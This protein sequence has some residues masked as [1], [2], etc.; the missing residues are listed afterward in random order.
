MFS[1]KI[2]RCLFVAAI[3]LSAPVL[4]ARDS[5]GLARSAYGGTIRPGIA[6]RLSLRDST[7]SAP[8]WPTLWASLAT[9]KINAL[10]GTSGTFGL[11]FSDYQVE[12]PLWSR[13]SFESPP[14]S[15]FGYLFG[16]AIW[17]G[18]IVGN[19]T[20]VSVGNDGWFDARDF[21][22]DNYSPSGPGSIRP[23]DSVG[24][25]SL[26]SQ[27]TDTIQAGIP[28]RP[29]SMGNPHVPLHIALANHAHVWT[30]PPYN[31]CLVYDLVITN[32]GT[33]AIR[34]GYVGMFV[35][36]DVEGPGNQAN[37]AR[38]DIVGSI[39]DR[40]LG[41]IID[42]DGDP[43]NGAFDPFN[44]PRSLLG[45]KYLASSFQPTDTSFNWWFG[46]F[47]P[48]AWVDFGPQHRAQLRQLGLGGTGQ[49]VTDAER[50]FLMSGK[51]WDYDQVQTASISADDSVWAT[52][53]PASL[54]WCQGEDVRF[55]LSIGPFDLPPDSSVRVL[56]AY[57]IGD[58]VHSD[59]HIMDYLPLAPDLYTQSLDFKHTLDA[60]SA[61]DSLAKLVLA[62]DNP[63]TGLK[64]SYGS[65]DTVHLSWDPWCFDNLEGYNV[66]LTPVPDSA[67]VH[68][69]VLPIWYQPQTPLLRQRTGRVSEIDLTGMSGGSAYSVALTSTTGGISGKLSTSLI[70]K[71]GFRSGVPVV[72]DTMIFTQNSAPVSFHW[73][74]STGAA[75]QHYNIYRFRD[76]AEY[77]HRY[78]PFYSADIQNLSPVDSVVRNGQVY[79]YFALPVLATVPGDQRSFSDSTAPDG[80]LLCV[81]AVDSGGFESDFSAPATVVRTNRSKDVL[82]LTD[83]NPSL[84]FVY[85]SIIKAFYSQ[86]LDGYTWDFFSLADTLQKQDCPGFSPTCFDWHHLMPYRLVIIDDGL[87]DDV[88]TYPIEQATG[89]F[90]RFLESGGRLAY[91]GSFTNMRQVPLDAAA[92]PGFV[93]IGNPF[94]SHYFGIDSVFYYGMFYYQQSSA[95]QLDSLYG[96]RSADSG[97]AG[98]PSLTIDSAGTPFSLRLKTYWQAASPPMVSTFKPNARG[99]VTHIY[100]SLDPS[101]SVNEQQPVGVS[102]ATD[103]SQTYAFGF[104]LWYMNPL[105]ARRLVD[106]IVGRSSTGRPN[107]EVTETPLTFAL[108]QNYPNPF[109]PT[110]R[111]GFELPRAGQVTMV[112]FNILGQ[113]VRELAN[114]AYAAG[115]H[116]I[117]WDGKDDW[118]TEVSSGIYFYR[119]RS[120]STTLS[121]KMLLLR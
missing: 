104:H 65:L 44:S 79:N 50:Y 52:P 12:Y 7:R 111:I 2:V 101:S 94:A 110:T 6:A 77:N 16:G 32:I 53:P 66:Y 1:A 87:S 74:P 85:P 5:R 97:S 106:W 120:G 109:N 116:E 64:I 26:Q 80:S 47:A 82:V 68:P 105:D 70:I 121:R 14:G 35:D 90:T 38:D 37:G 118:G 115:K 98:A 34:R 62:P 117:T 93:P 25:F 29:A 55:L 13:A 10:F 36:G 48:S 78:L 71:P 24:N 61:A 19:D 119:L 95:S 102:T 49:P 81:T 43:V 30:S 39:R 54:Q 75:P 4:E 72:S 69:G 46:Y 31:N 41:Y 3:I 22:P 89:A 59:P 84:N 40:G 20:L 42:N 103:S 91:F 28:G 60:A 73:S 57:L 88:L 100:R 18:G 83:G 63:P 58:S 113:R 56:Y 51:E 9:G 17:V 11:P 8:P 45:F 15:G 76:T 23:F 21:Y 107:N 86:V 96:F 114:R 112:I 99:T 27:F 92:A 33:Q 108:K 67:F